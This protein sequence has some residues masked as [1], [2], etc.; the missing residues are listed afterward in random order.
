M[1]R[2]AKNKWENCHEAADALF[3][4]KPPEQCFGRLIPKTEKPPSQQQR[5]LLFVYDVHQIVDVLE[6][7]GDVCIFGGITFVPRAQMNFV[8][9]SFLALNVPPS[10]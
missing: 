5:L 2:F 9:T 1:D 3:C 6:K 7:I 10:H 8:R 4:K